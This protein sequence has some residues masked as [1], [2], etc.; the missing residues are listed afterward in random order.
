MQSLS[1]QECDE[2]RA[3]IGVQVEIILDGYWRQPPAPQMKAAILADWMD[4]LQDWHFDQ[5]RWAL[6]SWRDQYPSK[7]PNP[8]HIKQLLEAQRGKAFAAENRGEK[9]APLFAINRPNLL[10]A[11]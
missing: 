7:K 6:R 8:G 4:T 10:A 3:A 2:H 11:Q 5:I 1:Q 9:P